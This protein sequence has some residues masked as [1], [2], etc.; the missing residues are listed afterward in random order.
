MSLHCCILCYYTAHIIRPHGEPPFP[1][2]VDSLCNAKT[3]YT[4][5]QYCSCSP[6][7][8]QCTRLHAMRA[9]LNTQFMLYQNILYKHK[10]SSSGRIIFALTFK[11]NFYIYKNSRATM[12]CILQTVCPTAIFNFPFSTFN[13]K[14]L[15]L[16]HNMFFY[17]TNCLHEL[18]RRLAVSQ[19]KKSGN[20]NFALKICCPTLIF[21]L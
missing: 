6:V 19:I 15:S 7:R 17:I 12:I 3:Y 9:N 11:R 21:N 2:R 4:R 16:W 8:V 5:A 13:F 1:I 18:V 20:R 14:K 10:Y